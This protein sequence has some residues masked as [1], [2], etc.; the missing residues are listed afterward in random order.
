MSSICVVSADPH[1]RELCRMTLITANV[2]DGLG[3][4]AVEA[5]AET[6]PSVILYDLLHSSEWDIVA[7]LRTA[8]QTREVPLIVLTAWVWADSMSR[9]RARELQC[10]AV[11]AKPYR[12]HVL[13]DSLR[14]AATL[15]Y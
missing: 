9:R 13:L 7:R 12:M 8:M 10:T 5:V 4:D 14:Q 11:I 3:A 6:E 15:R 2:L 1:F